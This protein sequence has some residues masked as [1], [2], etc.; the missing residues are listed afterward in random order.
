MEQFLEIFH[1]KHGALAGGLC[2][3]TQSMPFTWDGVFVHLDF[4]AV[5]SQDIDIL[6]SEQSVSGCQF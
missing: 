5:P 3:Q 6:S 4:K 2:Y 1:I